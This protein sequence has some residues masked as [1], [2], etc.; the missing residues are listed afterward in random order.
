M[1]ERCTEVVFHR[2]DSDDSDGSASSTR[3]PI[4]DKVFAAMVADKN[5]S[6]NNNN[7]YIVHYLCMLKQVKGETDF[8][9]TLFLIKTV[10]YITKFSRKFPGIYFDIN[11]PETSELLNV[12]YGQ[13]LPS[14]AYK[15]INGKSLECENCIE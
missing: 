2:I 5:V 3:F 15:K 6:I 12:S 8:S 7:S 14:K 4:Q 9:K 1:I 11:V 10:Y 13:R